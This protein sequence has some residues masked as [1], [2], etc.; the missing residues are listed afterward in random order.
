MSHGLE[1]PDGSQKVKAEACD[2]TLFYM[3]QSES[4]MGS[5]DLKQMITPLSP[6]VLSFDDPIQLRKKLADLLTELRKLSQ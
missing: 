6:K 1:F 5:D 4:F 3:R 2:C